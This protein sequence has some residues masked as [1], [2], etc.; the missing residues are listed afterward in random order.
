MLEELF[1]GSQRE[2]D[3]AHSNQSQGAASD[4]APSD[5]QD[6][7]ARKR[8]GTDTDSDDETGAAMDR[9]SSFKTTSSFFS[10]PPESPSGKCAHCLA[11]L[12]DMPGVSECSRR[13][14]PT[15]PPCSTTQ[16]RVFH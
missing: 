11:L 7:P 6:I 2:R 8:A 1:G 16:C 14:V 9:P 13:A 4:F 15:Y 10:T 12:A 3:R 5:A